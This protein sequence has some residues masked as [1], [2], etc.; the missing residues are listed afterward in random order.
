MRHGR[1]DDGAASPWSAGDARI[2]DNIE[3]GYDDGSRPEK[4]GPE[5][6]SGKRASG[7]HP[8][9]VGAAESEDRFTGAA[10]DANPERGTEG[11][12]RGDADETGAST[13]Q[14]RANGRCP[15]GAV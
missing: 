5:A 8:E 9:Q 2:N 11:C 13:P 14:R 7:A 12:A 15:R 4:G 6:R 3:T 10:Q 1:G